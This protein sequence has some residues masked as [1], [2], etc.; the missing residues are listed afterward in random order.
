MTKP[1]PKR[2]PTK[3][4]KA[5]GS[6]RAKKRI[7]AEAPCK[8]PKRPTWLKG[9]ARK[10]WDRAVAELMALGTLATI[11]H[12]MLEF[13]CDAYADW[14][15]ARR[16]TAKLKSLTVKSKRGGDIL[17]PIVRHKKD[18]RAICVKIAAE[19]GMSPTSRTGQMQA[20][21]MAPSDNKSKFFERKEK[22]CE[23]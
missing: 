13:Y 3:T 8:K 17:H 18:A 5:R 19:L 20:P 21:K 10:A 4:L 22:S 11:D 12:D 6:W 23:R 1:G 7:G 14:K 15:Q 16:D 9:D 2:T